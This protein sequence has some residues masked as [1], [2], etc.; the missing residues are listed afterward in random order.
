VAIC[1]VAQTLVWSRGALFSIGVFVERL[2]GRVASILG[3]KS[4]LEDMLWMSLE[5]QSL[6]K[7]SL[8]AVRAVRIEP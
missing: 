1:H 8:L 7:E 3:K 5:T 2:D 4:R 6:E